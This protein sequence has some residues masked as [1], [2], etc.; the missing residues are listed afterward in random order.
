MYIRSPVV[1]SGFPRLVLVYSPPNIL[2][3]NSSSLT[4]SNY[5]LVVTKLPLVY[6]LYYYSR[7]E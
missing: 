4:S 7:L 5:L 1:A 2:S 3:A 6:S